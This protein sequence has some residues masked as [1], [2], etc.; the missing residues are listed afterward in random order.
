MRAEH[1]KTQSAQGGSDLL[2]RHAGKWVRFRSALTDI[3][4][5]SRKSLILLARLAGFEPT[6][7]WFEITQTERPRR[8][9][10][11]KSLIFLARLAGFEPTTPWFVAKSKPPLT[12]RSGPALLPPHA[13]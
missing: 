8:G 2:R 1:R 4:R 13:G 10:A 3:K 11:S 7:P 12:G 5:L 9:V 6:T